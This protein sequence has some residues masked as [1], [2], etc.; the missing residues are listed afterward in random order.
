[1][2][3]TPY[4]VQINAASVSKTYDA[5]V[6]YKLTQQDLDA[7]T[8]QLVGSDFVLDAEMS[9]DNA[10]VSRDVNG[11]ER[12]D[13]VVT[14]DSIVI[15]DGNNGNNYSFTLAGNNTSE[16]LGA[17][18]TVTPV[19]DAKLLGQADD[20]NYRGLIYS[21]F[22]AGEN[23]TVFG[24][25]L[26]TITRAVGETVGSYALTATGGS[27]NNYNITYRAGAYNILAA[28]SFLV[29]VDA[30]SQPTEYGSQANFAGT[31]TVQ[32]MEPVPAQTQPNQVITPPAIRTYTAYFDNASQQYLIDTNNDG[33]G[34]NKASFSVDVL[35]GINSNAGKLRVG[36]YNLRA[37]EQL[38]DE[39]ADSQFVLVGSLTIAPKTINPTDLGVAGVDKDYDGNNRINDIELDL[40]TVA[41]PVILANDVVTATG[42]GSFSD[43]HV[44]AEQITL[45]ITLAGADAS[46]YLL[47]S[48]SLTTT[49]QIN[50]LAEV[51][52]VGADFGYWADPSN[53][54]GGAIPDRKD[55]TAADNV[56]KVIIGEDVR[57]IYDIDP[58]VGL[59][60]SEIVNDGLLEIRAGTNLAMAN[61]ISGTGDLA[62]HSTGAVTISGDNSFA[63]YV[64]I[65][66]TDV[67][68]THNNALGTAP[69]I[70][71]SN[72]SL[73][74]TGLTLTELS[75]DGPITITS[76]V[77]TINDQT[78]KGALTFIQSGTPTV[79]L[80]S[81]VANFTSSAGNIAF[82]D[83]VSAG[84]NS[85]GY[86]TSLVV[87]AAGWVLINGQIGQD[88]KGLDY[89][90]EY[91]V[92]NA[93]PQDVSPYAL[94]ITA[95]TIK[96]F[97]DVTTFESQVYTGKI[98]VGNNSHDELSPIHGDPDSYLFNGYTRLLVSVD[99]SITLNGPIDDVD[100]YGEIHSLDLR[101]I[102]LI[103]PGQT[104]YV[105]PEI[106]INGDIGSTSPLLGLT[107]A[108]GTQDFSSEAEVTDIATQEVDRRDPNYK[109]VINLNGSVEVFKGP[110]FIAGDLQTTGTPNIVWY[111]GT[112]EFLL[113]LPAL[114]QNG[115]PPAPNLDIPQVV[116]QPGP[117]AGLPNFVAEVDV[118]RVTA[119]DP[120]PGSQNNNNTQLP[121][122]VGG[123]GGGVPPGGIVNPPG[124][125]N[126]PGG[127]VNPP[128]GVVNPPGGVVNP[129]GGGNVPG[130][131]VNPPGGGTSIVDTTS[132]QNPVTGDLS[133]AINA[134]LND[135]A[136]SAVVNASNSASRVI[137]AGGMDSAVSVRVS[138]GQMSFTD[139]TQMVTARAQQLVNVTAEV[140]VGA[141]TAG[142]DNQQSIS[143]STAL[144]NASQ[145]TSGFVAVKSVTPVTV[146]VGQSFRIALPPDTFTH[147]NVG[148]VFSL[149]ASTAQGGALP[150]WLSFNPET[151]VFSGVAPQGVGSISVLVTAT[152]SQQNKATTTLELRFEGGQLVSQA[153]SQ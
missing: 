14:L 54:L 127:V 68:V 94:E 30:N 136:Q 77:N 116:W 102:S 20:T 1:V 41:N 104:N 146:A 52:W 59:V 48:T 90:D 47:S 124:G 97:A 21:G 109:G 79:G 58:A 4:V 71:S 100:E 35:N 115:N 29:R 67:T 130:T 126:I 91:L 2:S 61:I 98:L 43:R 148:E 89:D 144:S 129:P 117:D 149:S 134:V 34:D 87:D 18:L 81:P 10:N 50:Q 74:L 76:A 25:N 56:A 80:N 112:P 110:T 78:Y 103:A 38:I 32:Y 16:I 125:G 84:T 27:A 85:K 101:A 12:N 140:N 26:P 3:V 142:A 31:L 24:G 114:D 37:S 57:V 138:A 17:S 6:L 45:D 15:Q 151:G 33:V 99:P 23:E 55:T 107:I 70:I 28:D 139:V 22:V 111:V 51:Q 93:P 5:S 122:N 86:Q 66:S 11:I 36:G 39:F 83:A 123:G 147:S 95:D 131:G 105:E 113:R 137:P 64:D 9:F 75:V 65:G 121:N 106:S 44:G 153:D 42:T 49:G 8:N 13:R 73:D 120:R 19:N 108:T 135:P 132:P 46:N 143:A 62:V 150:S 141:L 88:L 96:L 92:N 63:G 40:A 60:S 119:R 128:G 133:A 7:L 82:V 118:T 152:D 53:W 69:N 145:T 72:G